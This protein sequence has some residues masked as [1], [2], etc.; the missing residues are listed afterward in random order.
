LDIDDVDTDSPTRTVIGA[1]K[2]AEMEGHLNVIS[3]TVERLEGGIRMALNDLDGGMK[4][5]DDV[6]EDL[7]QVCPSE[8]A[9]LMYRQSS[10]APTLRAW[11]SLVDR[12]KICF[13]SSSSTPR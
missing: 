2:R 10:D 5:A 1:Q 13:G 7:K 6:Y 4:L 12:Q 8:H 11:L 9:W 3:T